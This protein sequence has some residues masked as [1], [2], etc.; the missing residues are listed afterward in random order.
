[1]RNGQS[2][3]L[4]SLVIGG[5]NTVQLP[6][7]LLKFIP[8]FSTAGLGAKSLNGL[9]VPYTYK[10]FMA[11]IN[12]VM[13]P[14]NGLDSKYYH[15]WRFFFCTANISHARMEHIDP[16]LRI[17]IE[18]IS[19]R[20]EGPYYIADDPEELFAMSSYFRAVFD[21]DNSRP[22]VKKLFVNIPYEDSLLTT[23]L[24]KHFAKLSRKDDD[25]VIEIMNKYGVD[26]PV[27]D[28]CGST[29]YCGHR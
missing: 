17:P 20:G 7:E 15:D 1:M 23:I 8:W 12:F 6:S 11:I 2:G 4:V 25:E 29:M 24:N 18:K 28:T 27:C 13:N 5:T 16:M 19:I 9:F 10:Q 22:F 26:Y 14:E 3:P 21:H